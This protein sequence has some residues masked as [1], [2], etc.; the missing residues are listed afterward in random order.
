M[1]QETKKIIDSLHSYLEHLREIGVQV[2]PVPEKRRTYTLEE[3]RQELG[4]CTRCKLHRSRRAIVFGEGNPKATLM[5]VGEGPGYDEDLQG[6]PFVG[7]AGQLLTRIIQSI[8]LERKDVYITN[9]VKCRPPQNRNPEPD[10]IRSC[11]PFLLQQIDAI[12]PKIICALGTV[13]AQTLLNTTTKITQLR[14]KSY[15]WGEI[16]LFPTYHPAYLLRNPDRKREVWEDMKRI[17]KELQPVTE[18]SYSERQNK[19][20]IARNGV[21]KQSLGL[22]RF[23]RNDSP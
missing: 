18:A 22:L 21:T 2:L 13:A 15:S 10:E 17:K 9:I 6:R 5:I 11:H 14:G 3:V 7:K 20:V 8:Q 19:G 4:E 1:D 12:Q 16:L 23:A